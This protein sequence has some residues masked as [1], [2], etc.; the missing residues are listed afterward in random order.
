MVAHFSADIVIHVIWTLIP[1]R[2]N[3]L[4]AFQICY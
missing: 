4:R 2:L 1:E 3:N